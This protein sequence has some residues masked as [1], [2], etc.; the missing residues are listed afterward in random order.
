[1]EEL[2]K[3]WS[4][5]RF[6]IQRPTGENAKGMVIRLPATPSYWGLLTVPPYGQCEVELETDVAKLRQHYRVNTSHPMVV[7]SCTQ[8]VYD[9]MALGSSGGVWIR[10]RI[11]AGAGLRP[12]FEVEIIVQNGQVIASRSE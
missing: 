10:G 3:P 11:V 1:V 7:D 4:V 5:V 2:A 12:P 8:T 9:P 6:E